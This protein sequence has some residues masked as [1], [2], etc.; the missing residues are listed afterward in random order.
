MKAF[1]EENQTIHVSTYDTYK[2]QQDIPQSVIV[3]LM[4]F[5]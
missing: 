5:W 4:S 3:A 1:K 2:F